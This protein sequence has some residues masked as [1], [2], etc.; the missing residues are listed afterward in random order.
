MKSSRFIFD[1][2]NKNIFNETEVIREMIQWDE[3]KA[4]ALANSDRNNQNRPIKSRV[5]DDRLKEM[6][7]SG[8]CLTMHQPWAGLLIKVFLN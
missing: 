4:K 8:T 6:F 1:L 7:D 3:Q 5:Q 2:K